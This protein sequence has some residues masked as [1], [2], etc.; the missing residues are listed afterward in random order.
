VLDVGLLDI[1][2]QDAQGSEVR[3]PHLACLLRPVRLLGPTPRVSVEVLAAPGDSPANLRELLLLA[4]GQVGESPTVELVQL[5]AQ[6]ARYRIAVT[7]AAPDARGQLLLLAHETMTR[8][9]PAIGRPPPAVPP[10]PRRS[11]AP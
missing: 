8:A 6:G 2:L 1:R 5:D 3:V 9:K 7:T 4:V 10:L 11:V